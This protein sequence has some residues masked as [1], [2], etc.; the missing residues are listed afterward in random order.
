VHWIH[1]DTH[2][3]EIAWRKA[4]EHGRRAGAEQEEA[5]SLLWLGSAA[6]FGPTPAP[7]G[8]ARCKELLHRLAHR[9]MERA[10]LI[11]PL[12]A[13][14]AMLGSFDEARRLLA[15]ANETLAD[16]GVMLDPVSHPEA[17]VAML[18]GDPVEAERC[19][20]AD[21]DKLAGMG[22]KG[23][24]STTAA[25][26]ARAVEAQGRDEE[27]YD[28]T[29]VAEATGASD[30]FSTQVVW[31][32]VRARV[33]AKGG[34]KGEAERLAREAVGLAEQTDRLNHHG[35]A[36]VDLAAVLRAAERVGDE[37]EALEAALDL[38]E[39]KCNR[40]AAERVG[41]RLDELAELVTETTPLEV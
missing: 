38:F 36:L 16:F 22:E 12:A 32:G 10:L 31:R 24:L 40:V 23:F 17:Y 21:Y 28:L 19:L 4:A 13:L 15:R 37:H 5:D 34:A 3:A 9:R 8:V 11:H 18:A 14:V 29:E 2:G 1:G 41:A 27:A 25:L 6:L 39:R 30:D 26:L 20:R 33:M 35:G 7:E